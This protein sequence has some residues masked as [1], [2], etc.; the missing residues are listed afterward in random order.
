[1]GHFLKILFFFF[2]FICVFF[3]QFPYTSL[4]PKLC[5]PL[6]LNAEV[7]V[8]I[9]HLQKSVGFY[10]FKDIVDTFL[11]SLREIRVKE[12]KRAPLS[13]SELHLIS[14]LLSRNA[15]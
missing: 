6:R 14:D 4:H 10:D 7:I 1:M 5:W 13:T 12:S 8:H 3:S 2:F 11:E 9:V 15:T